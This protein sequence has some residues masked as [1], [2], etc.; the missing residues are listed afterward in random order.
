M[1]H[2]SKFGISNSTTN[3]AQR[4][5]A[6]FVR[7]CS[8]FRPPR[9]LGQLSPQSPKNFLK[10]FP[11]GIAAVE[12][13]KSIGNLKQLSQALCAIFDVLSRR[14]AEEDRLP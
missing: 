4:M 14:I 3:T 2:R 7:R 12:V 6:A 10:A 11:L 1:S 13:T 5:A 8:P 9:V